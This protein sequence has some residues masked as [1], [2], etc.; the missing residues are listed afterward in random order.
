MPQDP[1]ETSAARPSG[2]CRKAFATLLL[3][4]VIFGGCGVVEKIMF[5]S[6]HT[7]RRCGNL[8]LRSGDALLDAEWRA[9]RP[10]APV[11]L[12]SHGNSETLSFAMPLIA[13]Y[14]RRGYGIMAYD[15]AGYGGSTGKAGEKQACMDIDAAYRYL[16]G[17]AG[18]KPDRI[19]LLG[20]SIGCGP[21]CYA[22]EKYPV[23]AVVLCAPFA[24][25]FQV[26]L[27]FPLPGDHFPNARRLSRVKTPL[28]LFHGKKDRIIP[29]R[30][31]RKVYEMSAGTPK[32]F[33]PVEGAGHNNIIDTLGEAYWQI[34]GEFTGLPASPGR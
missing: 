19:V 5:P 33:V 3:A 16:T 10:G 9:G 17:S 4:A 14:A 8:T 2:R 20:F 21:S 22:A 1:R 27:P 31:G 23:R 29:F 13:E 12:Y 32:R 7:G 28:L 34:L 18:V 24:S 25:A 15:Y 26:V 6:P 11:I 30:N